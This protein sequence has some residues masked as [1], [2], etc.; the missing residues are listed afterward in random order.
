LSPSGSPIA[1][2]VTLGGMQVEFDLCL[3]DPVGPLA[4]VASVACTRYQALRLA[5]VRAVTLLAAMDGRNG[6][7]AV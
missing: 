1:V 6:W 2:T 5:C 7:P 4:A 3:F